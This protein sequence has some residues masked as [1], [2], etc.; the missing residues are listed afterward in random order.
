MPTYGGTPASQTT[1]TSTA[2]TPSGGSV[3]NNYYV[4]TQTEP[5]AAAQTTITH[6]ASGA[7]NLNWAAGN[8]FLVTSAGYN[9]TGFTS[10]NTPNSGTV[11][12]GTLEVH[13]TGGTDL[14]VDAT[15]FGANGLIAVLTV[16]AGKS[17]LLFVTATG[18]VET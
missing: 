9:V 14:T 13:N 10:S 15:G 7:V 2:T 18:T 5:G 8:H 1:T 6:G 12:A 16:P 3:T 17:R 11:Q 4:T